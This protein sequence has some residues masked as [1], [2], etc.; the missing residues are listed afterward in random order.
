MAFLSHSGRD[1]WVARQCCRLIEETGK[2]KIGVFLDEKDIEGGQS[3]VETIRS[4]IEEC[5]ELVVL[6]TPY[7]IDREWVL[8]EI[9]AAWALRKRI[10]VIIDKV[11]PKKM[12]DIVSSYKAIDLNDFDQYLAQLASRV[13]ERSSP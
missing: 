1:R 11:N 13:K 12:P 5:D 7:S 3:I 6:L 9:S 2:G 8:V 4:A 10:I